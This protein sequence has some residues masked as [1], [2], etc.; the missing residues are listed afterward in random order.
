MVFCLEFAPM[1]AVVVLFVHLIVS[2]AKLLGPGDS[3][4]P[5]Y[6]WIKPG[7]GG[8][9]HKD[10]GFLGPKFGA[11]AFG[12]GPLTSWAKVGVLAASVLAFVLGI[13]VLR[14]VLP[15]EPAESSEEGSEAPDLAGS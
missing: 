2:V 3:G 4:L 1:R 7:S 12:D 11:L 13:L 5:P 14:R 8:F 6:V 9:M 15:D 10:A